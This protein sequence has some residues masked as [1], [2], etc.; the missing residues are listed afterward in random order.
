MIVNLMTDCIPLVVC[1]DTTNPHQRGH[2]QEFN[3][4]TASLVERDGFATI[5]GKSRHEEM[6]LPRW[7]SSPMWYRVE[8]D[9]S[10]WGRHFTQQ[11][12]HKVSDSVEEWK[13]EYL[14]SEKEY[15]A[16]NGYTL[17]DVCD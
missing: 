16:K 8:K 15:L 13:Q 12:L 6:K 2:G 3:P 1:N 11:I 9:G 14:K 4:L 5:G 10:I 17:E 7:V